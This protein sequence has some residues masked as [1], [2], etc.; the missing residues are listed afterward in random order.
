MFL[1]FN[2]QFLPAQAGLIFKKVLVQKDKLKILLAAGLVGCF[3]FIGFKI[4]SAA[5]QEP[6]GDPPEDN[7]PAPVYQ[8][9]ETQ[10]GPLNIKGA[11]NEGKIEANIMCL[12]NEPFCGVTP[13]EDECITSWDDVQGLWRTGSGDYINDIYYN[14]G[15]AGIG[16]MTP[17]ETFEIDNT[18][19]IDGIPGIARLRI[20]DIAQNPELQLQ[21][22][23][24]AADHWAFYNHQTLDDLRIWG[25]GSD[26]VTILQNG[27]VGIG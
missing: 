12:C 3:I 21:Y 15:R 20:T 6:T 24:N 10:P 4:A 16:T 13:N 27:N 26:R 11:G 1:I 2:F 18:T 7:R 5:W 17:Q 22:G 9:T 19:E 25:G 14:R 23:A 8:Q